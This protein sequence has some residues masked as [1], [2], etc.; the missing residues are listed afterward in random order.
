MEQKKIKC[1]Q[2]LLQSTFD[3][4]QTALQAVCKVPTIKECNSEYLMTVA[5]SSQGIEKEDVQKMGD[6]FD[7][8][9]VHHIEVEYPVGMIITKTHLE[10]GV[11]DKPAYFFNKLRHKYNDERVHVKPKGKYAMINH[12]G[13]YESL[14]ESYE[15]LRNYIVQQHMTIIGNAYEQDILSYLSVENPADYVTSI[16]IQVDAAVM[17][18]HK[19]GPLGGFVSIEGVL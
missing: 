17:Q 2:K 13:P 4:T 19:K 16:A 9:A 14:P 12:K 18:F 11:Y 7:Y 3:M 6:H 10:Q 15:I 5:L 8:C 1:M